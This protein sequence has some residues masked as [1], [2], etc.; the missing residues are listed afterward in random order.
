M[1]GSSRAVEDHVTVVTEKSVLREDTKKSKHGQT[2]IGDFV[3]LVGN[4][5]F[6]TVIHPEGGTEQVTRLVSRAFLDFLSNVLDD[7]ASENELKPPVR[8]HLDCGFE[9]IVRVVAVKGVGSTGGDVPTQASSHANTAVLEFGLTVIC[10]D[11]VALAVGQ[12]KRV[13]EASGRQDT[14]YHVILPSRQGR[15]GGLGLMRGG[16]KG[17]GRA[18][19]SKER[20]ELHGE[21]LQYRQQ[22]ANVRETEA[23]ERDQSRTTIERCCMLQYGGLRTCQED[24]DIV[25]FNN[26]I[27]VC[28][29]F[30]QEMSHGEVL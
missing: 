9:R 20:H 23:E 11:L 26:A 13:K 14:N 16:G 29:S 5:S 21:L 4:P 7:A 19:E 18:E 6:V 28:L 1:Q 2:S 3:V 17:S 24:R 27:F 15:G 8:S 12:A 30:F 22:R 10:H 25:T